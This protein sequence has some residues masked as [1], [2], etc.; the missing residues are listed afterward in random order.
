MAELKAKRGRCSS[1]KK[2]DGGGAASIAW[3]SPGPD[4]SRQAVHSEAQRETLLSVR[5]FQVVEER[6]STIQA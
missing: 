3:R 4:W 1:R 5:T 6:C 2:E